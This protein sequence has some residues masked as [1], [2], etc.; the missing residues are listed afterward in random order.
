MSANDDQN[1]QGHVAVR[2]DNETIARLDA[3]RAKLSKGH[4]TATPSDV[5]RAVIFEGLDVMEKKVSGPQ[6]PTAA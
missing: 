6:P 4:Y 2:L 5:L 1:P 3:L